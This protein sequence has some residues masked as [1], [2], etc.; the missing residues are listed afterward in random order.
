MT[1][2][3]F[4]IKAKDCVSET[5]LWYFSLSEQTTLLKF[6]ETECILIY[7]VVVPSC[8]IKYKCVRSLYERKGTIPVSEIIILVC[9]YYSLPIPMAERAKAWVCSRSPALRVRI[10]P[11]AWLFVC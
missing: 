10:P 5:K 8:S 7:L 2:H 6:K 1:E 4:I 9:N 11:K 3:L